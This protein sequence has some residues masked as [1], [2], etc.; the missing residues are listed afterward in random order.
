[1]QKPGSYFPAIETGLPALSA[2]SNQ[3]REPVIEFLG[4]LKYQKVYQLCENYK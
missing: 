2:G 3:L 4:E 1:M